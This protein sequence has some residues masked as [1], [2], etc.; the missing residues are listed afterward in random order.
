MDGDQPAAVVLGTP[1]GSIAFQQKA[2]ITASDKVRHFHQALAHL[3]NPQVELFLARHSLGLCRI[4]H[5]I[6]TVD[7]SHIQGELD[8]FDS[9]LLSTLNRIALTSLSANAWAQS[10]LPI[11]M[12]GLSLSHSRLIAPAAYTSSALQFAERATALLLPS[13][14]SHPTEALKLAVNQLPR[15]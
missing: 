3:Q 15:Q 7:S 11:R 9:T 4:T 13:E 14:A 1:V 10:G 6:R 2:L 12:G 5:L 8:T